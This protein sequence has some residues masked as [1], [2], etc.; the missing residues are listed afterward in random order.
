MLS[1][2]VSSGAQ[3][4]PR[5]HG[6]RCAVVSRGIAHLAERTGPEQ[7]FAPV[8][9]QADLDVGRPY[10]SQEADLRGEASVV[11]WGS[12][13]RSGPKRSCN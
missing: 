12:A 7:P 9:S 8:F 3:T 10:L 1:N 4:P 2:H 6:A 11:R 13:A 5:V